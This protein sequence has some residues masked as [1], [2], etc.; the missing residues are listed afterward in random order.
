MMSR[1]TYH[2][3]KADVHTGEDTMMSRETYHNSKADVHT[4][5]DT[6]MSERDI[7]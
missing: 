1:E 4:G 6:M 3:S 5:E 7:S 2:N